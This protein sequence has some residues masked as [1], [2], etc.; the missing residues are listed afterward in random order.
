MKTGLYWGLGVVLL[1]GVIAKEAMACKGMAGDLCLPVELQVA[2]EKGHCPRQN[3]KMI[4]YYEDLID[5]EKVVEPF[6]AQRND[7]GD[8]FVP[9]IHGQP[10]CDN[11]RDMLSVMNNGGRQTRL[12][13]EARNYLTQFQNNACELLKGHPNLKY[14]HPELEYPELNCSAEA[15]SCKNPIANNLCLPIELQIAAHGSSCPKGTMKIDNYE[16]LINPIA[17]LA[18]PFEARKN[19]NDGKWVIPKRNDYVL[20]DNTLEML[21]L[22]HMGAEMHEEAQNYLTQFQNK[23]CELRKNDRKLHF[24]ELRCGDNAEE[25][26]RCN[27]KPCL[28]REL[29][30]VARGN[31]CPNNMRKLTETNDFK[32]IDPLSPSVEGWLH[33]EKDFNGDW[34]VPERF[35]GH[36]LCDSTREMLPVMKH[37]GSTQ[38]SAASRS[39]LTFQDTCRQGFN[40]PQLSCP[41]VVIK[42][43]SI[44]ERVFAPAGLPFEPVFATEKTG[45]GYNFWSGV[46]KKS[47]GNDDLMSQPNSVNYCAGLGGGARLP[48]KDEYIALSRAMGSRDPEGDP[49]G[50]VFD[51]A[52]K[53]YLIPDMHGRSFWS[54][55]VA[56]F[57]YSEGAFCFVGYDGRIGITHTQYGPVRC[58][59]GG[60]SPISAPSTRP[61]TPSPRPSTVQAG[62]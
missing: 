41:V 37:G 14:D 7:H 60:P 54:A 61:S 38:F 44:N 58:V 19:N 25:E 18:V 57:P 13:A 3:M 29:L 17:P 53:G 8:L 24:K 16:D 43:S 51:I 28:P 52:Y 33:A 62:V 26:L 27:G 32:E 59:V 40:S 31:R 21:A 22:K 34:K 36:S 11:T 6:V 20:C 1:T 23:A 48:T 15:I 55:S 42:N 45:G 12:S 50:A 9:K 4:Y 2:G 30:F 49:E 46:V 5:P 56:P 47:D 35:E 39:Y 10:L